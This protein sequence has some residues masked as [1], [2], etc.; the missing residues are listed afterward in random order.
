MVSNSR[1]RN[2]LGACALGLGVA[3]GVAGQ[4]HAACYSPQQ[5]LPAQVVNDFIAN[6]AAFLAQYPNGGA[7]MISRLRDLAASNPAV[8]DAIKTLIANGNAAQKT[9]IGT[10]LGQAAKL[11]VPVDQ[12]YA[13]DLQALAASDPVVTV[14]Y[15]GVAGNTATGAAGG[16]GG[17]G[18][19]GAGSGGISGQ[20][21][22][23]GTNGGSSG[24]AGGG[25]PGNS[26]F[27]FTGGGVGGGPGGGGPSG[28][29]I[30]TAGQ[31]VSP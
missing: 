10:G 12:N 7:A 4:G 6:P 11:C 16:G 22:A 13:N 17:G 24:G 5:Q 8:L 25:T 23:S 9:A 29:S 2:W 27:S 26:S 31:S 1:M 15:Q 14:A 3:L 28:N 19:G 30:I 18:G 21:F 20:T